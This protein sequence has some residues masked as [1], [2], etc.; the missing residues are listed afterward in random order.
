MFMSLL[1]NTNDGYGFKHQKRK[2]L[3][4]L[5]Q[6]DLVSPLEMIKYNETTVTEDQTISLLEINDILQIPQNKYILETP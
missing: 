5:N 1:T 2:I 6:S 3:S 4:M